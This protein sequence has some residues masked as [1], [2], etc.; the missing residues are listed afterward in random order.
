M[1]SK[2]EQESELSKLVDAISSIEGVL[3]VILF[4]SR[5]RGDYKDYSDYDLLV[6]F[7]DDETMWKNR[8]KLYEKTGK[9]GLFTQILTRSLREIEEATEPT[10]LE[11]VMKEG[12][13][14]YMRFPLQAPAVSQM[15]KPMTILS[16]RLENLAPKEKMKVAYRLFG[17]KSSKGSSKGLME[18]Y[19][20]MK[21]GD[22]CLIISPE[23]LDAVTKILKSY[24]VKFRIIPVFIPM[25]LTPP[26]KAGKI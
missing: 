5:A 6:I 9:L 1:K 25:S 23:G 3:S 22:G 18:K 8:R 21:L 20:G 2:N 15:L 11:N 12:K 4:G 26:E 14:L 19:G 7:R 24:N 10:F 16:Y 13:V 17:R